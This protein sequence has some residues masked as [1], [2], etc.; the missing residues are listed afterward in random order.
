MGNCRD[1]SG[2]VLEREIRFGLGV[3]LLL[4]C[5]RRVRESGFAQPLHRASRHWRGRNQSFDG[6]ATHLRRLDA[7]YVLSERR[8]IR[9]CAVRYDGLQFQRDTRRGRRALPEHLQLGHVL[10]LRTDRFRSDGAQ[11]TTRAAAARALLLKFM[12]PRLKFQLLRADFIA[13]ALHLGLYQGN[14]VIIAV[15]AIAMLA[16]H[17]AGLRCDSHCLFSL[18]GFVL[19]HGECFDADLPQPSG[20]SFKIGVQAVVF[21]TGH[22]DFAVDDYAPPAVLLHPHHDYRCFGFLLCG[23]VF[24]V[25]ASHAVRSRL[26]IWKR[27]KLHNL[28]GL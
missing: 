25:F 23:E 19:A 7:R 20:H 2:L 27:C 21:V 1:F 6:K 8:D 16:A 28:E 4:L 3:E 13:D 17:L 10:D 15:T 26:V 14:D 11:R 18:A 5:G 22:E 12:N 9:R 24:K